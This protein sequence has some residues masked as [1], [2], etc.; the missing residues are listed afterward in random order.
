MEK[1]IF[2]TV[3]L[4]IVFFEREDVVTTSPELYPS[5]SDIDLGYFG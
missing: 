3:K 2:E 5:E 4:E 1:R